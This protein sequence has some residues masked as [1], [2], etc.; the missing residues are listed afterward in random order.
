MNHIVTLRHIAENYTEEEQKTL[1]CIIA[2]SMDSSMGL[3]NKFY[4]TPAEQLSGR[5]SR[6][7]QSMNDT[8]EALNAARREGGIENDNV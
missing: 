1:L 3:F 4:D 7:V 6:L 5:L 8:V 2:L